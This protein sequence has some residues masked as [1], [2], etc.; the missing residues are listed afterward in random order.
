MGSEDARTVE[1]KL[2][3]L[4]DV[5][6][7]LGSVAVALSGGVDSTLLAKVAHDVLGD[8][9]VAMTAET[10]TTPHQDV[11]ATEEFCRDEGIR[12]IVL[13]YDELEIPGFAE[14]PTNRC[15]L[16]KRELFT[17]M[18][19]ACRE[20]GIG[21]VAEGS[22]LDDEGDFRPGLMAV[23][24]LHVESPL[25]QAGLHKS[26]VREVSHLLGLKTWD[27]PAAACLSSRF[28]Y[29][30]R[31]TVEKLEAIDRAEDFLRELGFAQCRVRVHDD[32]AR[33]EV[34]PQEVARLASPATA[35]RVAG[36]LHELGFTYVTVDL[37]GF[38]S[39]SMNAELGKKDATHVI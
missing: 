25:R 5:L 38:R 33:I 7:G 23:S 20:Q 22:N 2:G 1:Q 10:H 9:M 32:V 26:D 17:R 8:A 3:D 34:E 6:A 16:C 12:Q 36:R 13:H 27:K 15:Y 14:N 28:P 29:W 18:A 37:D 24:E 21:R 39:G 4:R 11:E 31:I 30:H 35:S 19:A